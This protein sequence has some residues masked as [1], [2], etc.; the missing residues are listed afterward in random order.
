LRCRL[1]E[2]QDAYNELE[3]KAGAWRGNVGARE[4]DVSIFKVTCL[5][6]ESSS[7]NDTKKMFLLRVNRQCPNVGLWWQGTKEGILRSMAAERSRN[8]IDA[9]GIFF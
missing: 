3:E 9:S 4:F 1:W 6:Y 8:E 5:A 7:D 2:R